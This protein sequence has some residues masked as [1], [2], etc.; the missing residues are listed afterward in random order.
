MG[1]SL[2]FDSSGAYAPPDSMTSL[3]DSLAVGHPALDR[4]GEVR[5]LLPQ[6]A[7]TDLFI[8]LFISH[9]YLLFRGKVRAISPLPGNW[10]KETVMIVGDWLR[11][12]PLAVLA[13][14][15]P[16]SVNQRITELLYYPV[17]LN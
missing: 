14:L 7:I 15:L 16:L 1:R 5:I 12:A 3:G 4:V 13:Q 8:T 11:T 6:P 2:D 10:Q 9:T 17:V